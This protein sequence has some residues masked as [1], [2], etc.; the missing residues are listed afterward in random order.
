MLGAELDPLLQAP[1]CSPR[2]GQ[3]WFPG[4]SRDELRPL[5]EGAS[6]NS[7]DQVVMRLG[8]QPPPPPP[9]RTLASFFTVSALLSLLEVLAALGELRPLERTSSLVGEARPSGLAGCF[10]RPLRSV[11]ICPPKPE[12]GETGPQHTHG[13]SRTDP[14]WS[15]AKCQ[16]LANRHAGC[17]SRTGPM[18]SEGRRGEWVGSRGKAILGFNLRH[19]PPGP[20]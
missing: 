7:S 13:A 5:S 16:P 2:P 4:G 17:P 11:D 9:R 19:L 14:C 3:C 18:W 8:Q 15:H 1:G 6:T 20:S 10:F 12:A